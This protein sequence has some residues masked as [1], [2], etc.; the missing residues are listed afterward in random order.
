MDSRTRGRASCNAPLAGSPHPRST[1]Q[2]LVHV[3]PVWVAEGTELHMRHPCLP[4]DHAQI[5]VELHSRVSSPWSSSVLGLIRWPT[6]SSAPL[7]EV[8]IL[9]EGHVEHLLVVRRKVRCEPLLEDVRQL[10]VV[11]LVCLREDDVAHAGAACRDCLLLDATDGEHAT[12]EGEL[13][14]HREI[15][16]CRPAHRKGEE[17]GDHRDARRGAILGGRPFRH[18]Y[19]QLCL[20]E[21]GVGWV[22]RH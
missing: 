20:L 7:L 21:E 14:R 10:L 3:P 9:C 15:R 22:S 13:A 18:V 4:T 12:R 6:A 1:D 5:C 8:P 19:V 11:T 2:V 17:R 16:A